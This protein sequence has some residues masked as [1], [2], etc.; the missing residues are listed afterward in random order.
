MDRCLSRPCESAIQ[1]YIVYADI[2]KAR[3]AGA[4][5]LTGLASLDWQ[6]SL[7]PCT[8]TAEAAGIAR[9]S[10]KIY[11]SQ[12]LLYCYNSRKFVSGIKVCPNL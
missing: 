10:D 2:K 3:D 1:Y 6:L 9:V 5:P 11:T 8:P 12:N 7:R 4:A